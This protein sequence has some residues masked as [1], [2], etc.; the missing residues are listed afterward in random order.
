[1]N[2]IKRLKTAIFNI[3]KYQDFT[4]EKLS[5]AIKYFL[6][7]IL[8][9]TVIIA[10]FFAYK[11]GNLASFFMD[12]VKSDFP[13]FTFSENV[14]SAEKVINVE[15]ENKTEKIKLIVDTNIENETE[16][17]NKYMTEIS[18][19]P[20]GAIFLKDRLIVGVEGLT[21]QITYDYK[22]LDLTKDKEFNKEKLIESLDGINRIPMYISI[23]IVVVLY[24]YII[25]LFVTA[26]D[27]AFVGI[28]GFVTTK[29]VRINIKIPLLCSMAIYSIT[30]SVMLNAIYTPLKLLTGFNM[31]YFDLMYTLIPYVYM[32]TA[33]LMIRADLIKQQI[34]IG[35]IKKVQEEVK[36]EIE[37]RKEEEKKK[38]K[39]KEKDKKEEKEKNEKGSGEPEG[40]EA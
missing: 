10:F 16:T 25:Y 14:M 9:L 37:E 7:L 35:K 11:F 4:Q 1:M 24:M 23:F 17:I 3:E 39:D 34:E 8:L 28:I 40:S 22:D 13:E 26:L 32:I 20:N 21:G 30:L 33:I 29:L 6:K 38:E 36:E 31:E 27:I 18:K 5:I 2:F 19:F 12:T 15:K